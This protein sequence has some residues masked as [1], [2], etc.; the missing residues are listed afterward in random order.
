MLRK[1][2][3]IIGISFVFLFGGA[4]GAVASS[5][6]KEIKAFLNPALNVE[7]NG[8]LLKPMKAL[9]YEGTTYLPV[10]D[11][12]SMAAL[13]SKIEFDSKNNKLTLGG[14]RYLNLYSQD[15]EGFYQLIINGNWHSSVLTNQYTVYSNSYMGIEYY[16]DTI[17]NGTLE[18]V[19]ASLLEQ[20][21][22][23]KVNLKTATKI[24]EHDAIE[25]SYKTSESVGKLFIV[26]NGL[27]FVFLDFFIDKTK[28]KESDYEEYEK[29]KA[30]FNV[31]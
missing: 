31:Q 1:K 15:S 17:E 30:S 23:M 5:K 20:Q 9:T 13:N 27:D 24:A 8:E 7:L 11:I 16:F 4:V 18:S 25:I 14:P 28:F 6:F 22:A 2:V 3:V 21:P 26:Q 19:T 29:I 10:R 12:A